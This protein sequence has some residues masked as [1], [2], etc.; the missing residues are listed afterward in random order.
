MRIAFLDYSCPFPYDADTLATTPMGGTEATVVRV[1]EGLA[2]R[3]HHVAVFQHNRT[4]EGTGLAH[5]PVYGKLSF[6]PDA[7][8]LLRDPKRVSIARTKYRDANLFLWC[9]DFNLNEVV[10]H[11]PSLKDTGVKILG[12]SR[13]HK[14]LI[15]DALLTRIGDV[16]GVT[17]D[18][19]YNPIAD[20][21]LPDE[22]PVD[23]NKLVFFSSPHKGLEHGLHL[24]SRISH[25]WNDYRLF[26]GNPGYLPSPALFGDK[27]VNLGPLTH[28]EIIK[29]VRSAFAVFHP[30]LVFPETFGLVHA[31]ANAVGTPVI[32]HRLGATPEVLDRPAEQLTDCRSEKAVIDRID[33]YRRNGRPKVQGKDA[34]RLSNILK[35]WERL[36]K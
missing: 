35:E 17:A 13:T 19:V 5:Y 27:V 26:V 20:D 33:F 32:A 1:A 10:E 15:L 11:Y 36:L 8:V 22:T 18:F 7:V 29:H 30:N 3:G 28:S 12:V 21:L 31:E 24:F 34:F 6:K 25:T 16:R 2:A 9:H 23:P 4:S 14:S